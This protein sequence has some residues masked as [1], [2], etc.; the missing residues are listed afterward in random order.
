[1]IADEDIL[2]TDLINFDNLESLNDQLKATDDQ[3]EDFAN[4]SL[5]QAINRLFRFIEI[6]SNI[7]LE[8]LDG[9]Y[10]KLKEKVQEKVKEAE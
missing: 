9:T 5:K 10:L 3:Q 6:E 4:L 1:L 8:R 2:P 7:S